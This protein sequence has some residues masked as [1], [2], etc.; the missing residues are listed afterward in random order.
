[1]SLIRITTFALALAVPALSSSLGSH[2]AHFHRHSHVEKRDEAFWIPDPTGPAQKFLPAGNVS[3]VEFLG[4]VTSTN[5]R[6]SRDCGWNGVVGKFRINSY[7]DTSQ[8]Q[9][10]AELDNCW[11]GSDFVGSNSA[12]IDTSNPLQVQDFNLTGGDRAQQFCAKM[13]I[14]EEQDNVLF[15]IGISNVVET[16]ENTGIIF[17]GVN[18][19]TVVNGQPV[20][21]PYGAGIGIIDASGD[22]PTCTR[23]TSYW[24]D[25]TKEPS[26]GSNSA[27]DGM[28]GKIYVFGSMPNGDWTRQYEVF[29][30][31][32]DKTQATNLDAYEYWDGLT[33]QPN[34][35]IN[36]T[37]SQAVLQGVPPGQIY[38]NPYLNCWVALTR[39]PLNMYTLTIQTAANLQG[40]WSSMQA[41]YT[42]T[43]LSPQPTAIYAPAA[44]PQYDPSGETLIVTY[45]AYGPISAIKLHF[46]KP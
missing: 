4:N 43:G 22:F 20:Q 26:W 11:D 23:T 32:V 36:P 41:V 46:T 37:A 19:R 1:M 40:P 6:S 31:R 45:S 9:E 7:G 25:V 29:L 27:V 33:F 42:E 15:A 5:S 28:D 10:G 44:H 35:L 18:N 8:C 12:A 17:T 14:P 38:W 13:D 30:A 24:W 34:R 21:D 2:H 3:K 39:D 16:G